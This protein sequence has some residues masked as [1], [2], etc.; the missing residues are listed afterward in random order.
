ML[1]P[2][3]DREITRPGNLGRK[4][5]NYHPHARLS[6]P[7]ACRMPHTSKK[8]KLLIAGAKVLLAVGIIAYLVNKIQ[9]DA[10]FARLME[11]PKHW[12]FIALAQILVLAAFACSYVRWYL[13][14]RG[15]NLEFQLA[16]AFRLGSLGFMLNQIMPGSVGG[17]LFK[18]AFIAHEQPGRRTEA[19]ASVFIDRFVGLVAMLVVASAG[20]QLASDSLKHSPFL[21]SLQS[22]VWS[23]AIGGLVVMLSLTTRLVS[24]QNLQTLLG[25]VPLIGHMLTRLSQ[26]L[27]NFRQRR[28]HLLAAFGLGL[29]THCMLITA[30]WCVSRGLPIHGPSFQ[31]NASIVPLALVAGALPL[32]P[33]GLGL[34]ETGLAKLYEAI[35]LHESDGA[36]V[37]LCY[38]ALTYVV[39]AVGG[40]YYLSAKKRMDR[41]LQEAETLAEELE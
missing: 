13:L 27:A 15:L 25:K 3:G 40:C 26:G 18:A 5:A 7:S 39:A 35:Q 23:A 28:G 11:Q 36:M 34:T 10:G 32:T 20:L 38:R 19:V 2:A 8:T 37:A 24:G 14:V 9:A 33:G 31:E 30:F 29:T 41:L 22:I 6:T 17:D 21:T 1:L 16:D 4:L 12:G